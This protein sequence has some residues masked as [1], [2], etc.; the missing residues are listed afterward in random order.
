MKQGDDG[1]RGDFSLLMKDN[2]P[3]ASYNVLKMFNHLSG[4]WIEFTGT[5]DDVCGVAAWDKSKQRLAIVLVNYRDRYPLPRRVKLDVA[6]LPAELQQGS[7]REWLVDG[8]HS[9]VWHKRDDAE[10][11]QID[12]GQV[13]GDSLVFQRTLEPN[14]VTLIEVLSSRGR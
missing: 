8:T 12:E 4:Q 7:W 2:V 11:E 5:D 6:E 3:K 14:S 9:N 1:F 13:S 10:L